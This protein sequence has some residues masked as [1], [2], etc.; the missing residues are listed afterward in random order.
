MGHHK[1]LL[2]YKKAYELAMKI[3][4]YPKDFQLKKSIH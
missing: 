1:E 4:E 2:A 3:F